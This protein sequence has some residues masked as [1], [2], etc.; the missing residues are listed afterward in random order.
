MDNLDRAL[1]AFDGASDPKAVE[2]GVALVLRLFQ[3]KLERLDVKPF[4]SKGQPFDPRIHDAISQVPTD[5]HPA[6]VVVTELQR[7]YRLGDRLLRP[8]S[9]V[10]AVAKKD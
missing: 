4:E 3:S 1:A 6:G 7:G 5:D 8:A 10:V 2:Q 9:V